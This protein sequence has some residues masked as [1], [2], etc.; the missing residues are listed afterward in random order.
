MVGCFAHHAD[1]SVVHLQE[2]EDLNLPREHLERIEAWGMSSA[3]TSY[4]FRPVNIEGIADAFRSARG[5]G[6]TVAL[7]GAGNSYGDAFQNPEGIV[8]DLTRMARILEYDPITG[9]VKCEPGVTLDMLWK[10]V[11]GD[12]WWP[13]VVSGTSK[14]TLGGALAANIHGKNNYHAGPIGEHV[15]SFDLVLP[16]G[17]AII[18]EPGQDLFYAVIGG[19]GL[20]GAIVSVTLR[21]KKLSSG[22]LCV[23]AQAC[24]NWDDLFRVFE[25]NV[26]CDYLVGWID[27]FAAGRKAGR[28]LVHCAN[29]LTLGEDPHPEESLSVAAQE[30]PDTT[31]GWIPKS[32]LHRLMSPFVSRLGMP[33]TNAVKYRAGLR[34][35]GKVFLQTFA[36]FNFLLDSVPN[37]KYAYKPGALIQY[38]AFIPKEV[39]RTTFEDI[40]SYAKDRGHPAYL[41]VIK[42]HRPDR[43]LLSHSV[44]GYSLALDF[45]VK[46]GRDDEVWEMAAELDARV[47]SAG[48][49][50]YFAKDSTMTKSTAQSYLGSAL[51]EFLAIKRT[52]DPESI[53][54]SSLSRRIFG[55][56]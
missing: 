33:F 10:Y 34:E 13:P 46:K 8:I 32:K 1:D 6:L 16:N 11:I 29:Y 18:C 17:E 4:V 19:F 41:A 45:P 52:L 20:L 37:W 54:Q 27:A 47:L 31:M 26:H 49:R 48:G 30:L 2:V 53:L 38:Q 56:L 51:A 12:G 25:S 40:T 24:K 44:D 43:F 21:L 39:A 36:E 42:R 22:K 7:K 5:L 15:L 9:I 14:V 55:E 50:F 3:S 28:G 23:R 35:D